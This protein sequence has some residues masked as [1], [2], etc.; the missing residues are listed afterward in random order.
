MEG[1]GRRQSRERVEAMLVD[2]KMEE[3]VIAGCL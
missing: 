2:M 3:E 1:G